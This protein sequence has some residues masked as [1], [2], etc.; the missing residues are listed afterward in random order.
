MEPAG[1]ERE[2][3]RAFSSCPVRIFF[4]ACGPATAFTEGGYVKDL[5]RLCCATEVE[6]NNDALP[7]QFPARVSTGLYV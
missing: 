5:R 4:S 1:G 3:T 7:G 2:G 6:A